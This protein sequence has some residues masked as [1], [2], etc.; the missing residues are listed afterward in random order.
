MDAFSPGFNSSY[1]RHLPV[2]QICISLCVANMARIYWQHMVFSSLVTHLWSF[3]A[4]YGDTTKINGCLWHA[5]NQVWY[6][7]ELDK[8]LHYNSQK[9]FSPIFTLYDIEN[10]Q[11]CVQ[12]IKYFVRLKQ[13]IM[14]VQTFLN[15]PIFHKIAILSSVGVQYPLGFGSHTPSGP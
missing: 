14:K 13:L 15:M 4:V 3:C 1:H 12:F 5:I 2:F 9:C 10:L 6:M 11:R 7:S 8:E